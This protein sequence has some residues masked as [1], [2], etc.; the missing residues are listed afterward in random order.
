MNDVNSKTDAIRVLSRIT[1][2][3][4]TRIKRSFR[5]KELAEMGQI[6]AT[7]IYSFLLVFANTLKVFKIIS[8]QKGSVVVDHLLRISN[9]Q[10]KQLISRRY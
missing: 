5:V 2:G 4:L 6:I 1:D 3:T 8:L 10:Q 7:D 9:N